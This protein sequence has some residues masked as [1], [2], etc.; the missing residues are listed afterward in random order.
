MCVFSLWW[1][2]LWCVCVCVSCDVPPQ[3]TNSELY[4]WLLEAD[5]LL[6]RR[7]GGSND[8][9]SALLNSNSRA[10][11]PLRLADAG[12]GQAF[13]ERYAA[14]L[15]AGLSH[16]VSEVPRRVF[17]MFLGFRFGW[18]PADPACNTALAGLARACQSEA[19]RFWPEA[20]PE[21]FAVIVLRTQ[22]SPHCV[23]VVFP[24]LLVTEGMARQIRKSFL[25]YLRFSIPLDGPDGWGSIITKSGYGR[26]GCRSKQGVPLIS[27]LLLPFSRMPHAKGS[28]DD[29]PCS[30]TPCLCLGGHVD[31]SP[32]WGQVMALHEDAT[33]CVQRTSVGLTLRD[34]EQ[35]TPGFK[36]CRTAPGEKVCHNGRQ[37]KTTHIVTDERVNL[38]V[39]YIRERHPE[40]R[41]IE[42]KCLYRPR[43][44]VYVLT[45]KGEGSHYCHNI[46]KNHS[47]AR[48]YFRIQLPKGK[49]PSRLWQCCSA[50]DSP[51]EYGV[52]DLSSS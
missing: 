11:R 18:T 3:T 2:V 30:L 33:L 4:R 39:N 28:S 12:Q 48:I 21:T 5:C 22:C 49:E 27:D 19:R 9:P 15:R 50:P 37:P 24:D 45:V 44:H 7:E 13:C 17:R 34:D 43:H 51:F 26:G 10:K 41:R 47:G 36:P 52:P 6:P 31:S 29:S 20:L 40:Y 8:Q 14:D 35:P 25:T 42:P 32:D 46:G 1:D 38:L 16:S 23:R